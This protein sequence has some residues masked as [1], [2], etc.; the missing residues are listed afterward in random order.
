[1]GSKLLKDRMA[2]N[3]AV[4]RE[5]NERVQREIA[6]LKRLAKQEGH[7]EL[8]HDDDIPLHF[9]CECA[10]EN[11]VLRVIMKPSLYQAI[12]RDRN[13]F[14][15]AP[16]HDVKEIERV[17]DQQ[18]DYYVVE[19]TVEVPDSPGGLNPTPVKNV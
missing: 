19:K 10:D 5:H 8:I 2:E 1:M 9:Y 18:D 17:I 7:A 15:I 6:K 11:C 14:I 4:F 3:E 13:R 12:H 16:G